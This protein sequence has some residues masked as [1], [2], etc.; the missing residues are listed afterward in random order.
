M[1]MNFLI[2]KSYSILFFFSIIVVQPLYPLII[3]TQT[4][5]S[6]IRHI[7]DDRFLNEEILVIFDI[8]NTL[9]ESCW[10]L[11]GHRW[12]QYMVAKKMKEGLS[13]KDAE[14]AIFSVIHRIMNYTSMRTIEDS[15]PTIIKELQAAGI[16]TLVATGRSER[17]IE[18]TLAQFEDINVDF[19]NIW[20]E[21]H[22]QIDVGTERPIHFKNGILFCGPNKKGIAVSQFLKLHNIKPKK[23]IFIDD[24]ST[25]VHEFE[26]TM[27]QE[28]IECVVLHYTLIEKV[29]SP[30]DAAESEKKLQEIL[31]K[32]MLK[33]EAIGVK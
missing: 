8:D 33:E 28:G 16:R 21:F 30:F 19:S 3:E 25:Y 24:L 22:T 23:I 31:A 1:F 13:E 4:M 15:T 7:V 14:K 32:I 20:P 18:T 29:G 26:H 6:L 5:A 10:E 27:K 17:L 9:G 2:N 11:G 12:Y